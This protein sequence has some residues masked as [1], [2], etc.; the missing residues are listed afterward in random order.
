M[1]NIIKLLSKSVYEKLKL[2]TIRLLWYTVCTYVFTSPSSSST[3]RKSKSL[4]TRNCCSEAV[5]SK[6][7]S[8]VPSSEDTWLGWR[9]ISS[10]SPQ[11]EKITW[12]GK[13]WTQLNHFLF[14][15]IISSVSFSNDPHYC[16]LPRWRHNRHSFDLQQFMKVA[17]AITYRWVL[18]EADLLATQRQHVH[19]LLP[20]SLLRTQRTQL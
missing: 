2:P 7:S 6:V 15:G 3:S 16:L 18:A 8:R 11:E 13:H 20:C 4:K 9:S 14:H 10:R 12:E 17:R 1:L 5:S 19:Q